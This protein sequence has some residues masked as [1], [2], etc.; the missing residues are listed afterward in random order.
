MIGVTVVIGPAARHEQLEIQSFYRWCGY[1]ATISPNDTI[2]VARENA[3]VIGAV[4]LVDEH[5]VI[6][7]RWMYIAQD[8]QRRGIG[9]QLLVALEGLIG[10][11]ECYCIPYRHLEKFYAKIGFFKIDEERVPAYLQT[12]AAEYR[13]RGQDVILMARAVR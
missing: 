3:E 1:S 6:V 10:D 12:R 13:A 7:L 8:K 4:R 2:F 5:G 11:R 9:G